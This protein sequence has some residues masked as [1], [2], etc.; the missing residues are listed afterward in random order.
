[1]RPFRIV[2]IAIIA[3][4]SPAGVGAARATLQPQPAP[5]AAAP[6]DGQQRGKV[7]AEACCVQ[8]HLPSGKGDGPVITASGTHADKMASSQRCGRLGM[9]PYAK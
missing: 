6:G 9:N 5:A 3:G 4:L 1:M 7:I 8:C 2:V